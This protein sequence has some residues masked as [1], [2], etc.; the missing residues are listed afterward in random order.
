MTIGEL[1][2]QIILTNIQIWHEDTKLRNKINLT[3]HKIV[4]L[5]ITG[6]GLNKKRSDIKFEINKYFQV[7]EFDDRKINYTKGN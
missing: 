6:R 3:L 5:G 2:E 1:I 4:Q 7:E